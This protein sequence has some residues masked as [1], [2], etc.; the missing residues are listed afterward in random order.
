MS[1]SPHQ[2]GNVSNLSKQNI[3][4]IEELAS[5]H[6]G[7]VFYDTGGAPLEQTNSATG[8]TDPGFDPQSAALFKPEKGYQVWGHFQQ[9][10]LMKWAPQEP[11]QSS[12]WFP[13]LP[14]ST[15][16]PQNFG[17]SLSGMEDGRGHQA[18]PKTNHD[19]DSVQQEKMP[20]GSSVSYSEPAQ[21]IAP[22]MEWDSPAMA[23]MHH[24][25]FQGH[26]VGEP[27][28]QPHTMRHSMPD[29]SL[30]PFQV[31]FGPNKQL[32]T[33]EPCPSQPLQ[34]NQQLSRP[35]QQP[36]NSQGKA[37]SCTLPHQRQ[38]PN[39]Q[40]S[41]NK[42]P[43]LGLREPED[44][45]EALPRRSRRLSKD[46]LSPPAKEP[47]RNGGVPGVTGAFVGVIHTTQRRRRTSKEINLETL[48]QKASEMEFLPAR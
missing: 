16:L 40:P 32:Q 26:K 28:Y 47:A 43:D 25:Q 37:D 10:G 5:Q 14:N 11:V 1:L 7:E 9:S 39:L 15:K 19:M 29:T 30:Q 3:E 23:A 45:P 4:G 36:E 21:A 22:G 33:S 12:T 46:G 13:G 2:R 6:S 27:Q 41:T 18:L 31:A 48:A 34:Q 35:P 42:A 17:P 38:D 24:S 20:A 8:R 44:K